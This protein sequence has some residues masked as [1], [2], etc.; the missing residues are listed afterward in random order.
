MTDSIILFPAATCSRRFAP[1][2]APAGFAA[3]A[4]KTRDL[5]PPPSLPSPLMEYPQSNPCYGWLG[6]PS[7]AAGGPSALSVWESLCL[8]GSVC[9]PVSVW[10]VWLAG[11]SGWLSGLSGCLLFPSGEQNDGWAVNRDTLRSKSRLDRIFRGMALENPGKGPFWTKGDHSR[12][13]LE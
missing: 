2:A 3:R 5:R 12:A 9:L 8:S 13:H 6:R 4:E 7:E 11:S 10:L 1:L